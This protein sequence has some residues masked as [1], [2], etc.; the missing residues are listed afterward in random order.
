[1][2]WYM[3]IIYACLVCGAV[4]SFLNYRIQRKWYNKMFPDDLLASKDVMPSD[5]FPKDKDKH[6]N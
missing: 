1:M 2:S 5:D 3:L 6:D 4:S